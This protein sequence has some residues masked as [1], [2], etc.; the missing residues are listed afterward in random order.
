MATNKKPRKKHDLIKRYRTSAAH[1][2]KGVHVAYITDGEPT[3]D[4]VDVTGKQIAVDQAIADALDKVPHF[5]TAHLCV[6]CRANDG[7]Q[8]I[9][10]LTKP[11]SARYYKGDLVQYLNKA[12]SK[13][14]HEANP[15]H[16]ITCG[17]IATPRKEELAMEQIERIMTHLGAF[18]FL[19]KWEVNK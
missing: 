16:V 13:L 7:E 1:A 10:E 2:L 17:W 12:H 4:V 15:Q 18:N 3:C 5:W 8:Y 9:K 19:A 14:L 6:I 11:F